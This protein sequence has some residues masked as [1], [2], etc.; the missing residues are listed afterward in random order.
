[1]RTGVSNLERFTT[2]GEPV[3]IDPSDVLSDDTVN[4]LLPP[5][6]FGMDA[7]EGA[8][9]IPKGIAQ[10]FPPPVPPLAPTAWRGVGDDLRVIARWFY[11]SEELE[12]LAVDKISGTQA[13]NFLPASR[14]RVEAAPAEGSF[15]TVESIQHIE[16][17]IAAVD[18]S[19]VPWILDTFDDVVL[20]EL[21]QGA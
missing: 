8:R 13:L 18:D 20:D 10:N 14:F 6:N 21:L 15:G 2:T 9:L 5:G 7:P 1:M 17:R 12:A 16:S 4:G 19:R 3:S 11:P